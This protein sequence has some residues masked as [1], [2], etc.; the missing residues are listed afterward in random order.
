M[1]L[2]FCLCLYPSQLQLISHYLLLFFQLSRPQTSLF[3]EAAHITIQRTKTS[4]SSTQQPFDYT[5]FPQSRLT[6]PALKGL[7]GTY[8]GHSFSHADLTLCKAFFLLSI[9]S[10]ELYPLYPNVVILPVLAL[11]AVL[12]DIPPMIWHFSQRN[13]AAGSLILWI[14]LLNL[15]SII[16]PLIWPRDNVLE[17]WDGNVFC[18]IQARIQVGAVV[19]LASSTAM[20]MRKLANVMDTRNITVAPSH[21][22]RVREK[23]LEILWCWGYPCLL[24]LIYYVVQPVRYFIFGISGCVFA[25]DSSWPSLVLSYMW[26]PITMLVAAYYAGTS[27]PLIL[28]HLAPTNADLCYRTLV[29]PSPPLSQRVSQPHC[30]PKY[31]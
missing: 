9:M 7:V 28:V 11:L 20:V 10:T 24:M 2:A 29:L 4:G 5:S 19:A 12:L 18:D 1:N 17:W 25:Y 21:N 26:N 27:P 23:A 22:S 13:I 16:N 15:M 3:G 14:I 6:G 8:F 31:N 30:R